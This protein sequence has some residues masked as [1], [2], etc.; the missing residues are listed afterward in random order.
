MNVGELF[1]R[2]SFG[3]LA[4]L[5]IGTDGSGFIAETQHGRVVSYANSALTA[6]HSRFI[7]KINY[8][9]VQLSAGIQRYQLAPLYAV[10]NTTPNNTKPRYI[11]DTAEEPFPDDVVRIIQATGTTISAET[12]D[13]V[14]ILTRMVSH[15][16]LFVT[17]PVE[18]ALL[19]VEYQANHPRLSI[20][21]DLTEGI[22]LAPLLEEALE[23]R[24]AAYVY[25]AMDG[26]AQ[27]AK[28]QTLLNRFESICA[29]VKLES[30][31][32]E[33]APADHDRLPKGGWV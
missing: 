7:H 3:E 13:V 20:P 19:T 14:E 32:Q 24:I 15:D 11:I 26:E 22:S 33:G 10:S 21:V 1:Q 6:L 8:A 17:D 31:L 29:L 4:N 9:T 25:S 23:A 30:L 12:G 28:S 5:S 27:M 2:L 16:T 18:G